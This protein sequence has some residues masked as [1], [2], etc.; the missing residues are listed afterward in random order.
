M[1]KKSCLFMTENKNV[2]RFL[3]MYSLFNDAFNNSDYMASSSQ[4]L[5]H[6]KIHIVTD[7]NNK[8]LKN[9]IKQN[10]CMW[11]HRSSCI[12]T[13]TIPHDTSPVLHAVTTTC[14][15]TMICLIGFRRISARCC[16]NHTEPCPCTN[17]EN[18]RQYSHSANT[19]IIKSY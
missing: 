3:F 10:A 9:E 14:R 6:R 4:I 19:H 16:S 11:T 5:R 7:W 17:Q 15:M 12:I 13:C 18:N 2:Q 1:K 8:Y